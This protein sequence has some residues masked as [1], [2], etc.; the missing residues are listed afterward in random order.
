MKI[1]NKVTLLAVVAVLVALSSLDASAH[2]TIGNIVG[3]DCPKRVPDAGT[4]MPLLG[5]SLI[6]VDAIRR[7]LK[8]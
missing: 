6:A 2:I 8:A 4:M 3:I 7:K 5:M 1:S